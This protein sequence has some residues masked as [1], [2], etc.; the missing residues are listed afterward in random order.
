MEN[1]K[2]LIESCKG[3]YSAKN[4]RLIKKAI[5]FIDLNL[6]GNKKFSGKSYADFNIDV[7]EI[8]VRSGLPADV[9]IAGILYGVEKTI[10]SEKIS[11]DFGEEIAGIV[12]GQLQLRAIRNNNFSV[13]ADLVRKILLTGLND[14]RVVFVKLAVKLANLRI[15]SA[16]EEKGAEEDCGR[17]SGTLCSSCHSTWA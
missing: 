8:L 4:L 6:E 16:L 5:D 1:R 15:I 3:K 2:Q 11:K 7:G 12:F 13:Q 17:Y 9:I 10:T 14:A